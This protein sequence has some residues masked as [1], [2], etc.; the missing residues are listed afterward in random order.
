MSAI[1]TAM[2]QAWKA[3]GLVKRAAARGIS[4][5]STY[6]GGRGGGR[7]KSSD[8]DSRN[9]RICRRG[10]GTKTFPR[11]VERMTGDGARWLVTLVKTAWGPKI[12]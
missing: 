7:Q 4:G 2:R 9:G 5:D 10:M 3:V 12:S 8:R 11:H 1:R 6:P